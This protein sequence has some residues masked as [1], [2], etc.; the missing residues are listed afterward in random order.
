MMERRREGENA[1]ERLERKRE[2]ICERETSVE[3]DSR[4]ERRR[5]WTKRDEEDERVKQRKR[6]NERKRERRTRVQASRTCLNFDS[7]FAVRF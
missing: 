5:G 7:T 1:Q 4:N 2:R 3:Q 6:E